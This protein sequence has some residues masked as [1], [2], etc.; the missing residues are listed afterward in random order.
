MVLVSTYAIE[1]GVYSPPMELRRVLAIAFVAWAL[2]ASLASADV[3]I[4]MSDGRVSIVAEAAT[5]AEI[6]AE[7]SRVGRTHFVNVDRLSSDALSLTLDVPEEEALALLLQSAPGY[8]AALRAERASA[9]SRFDR[10]FIMPSRRPD[11]DEE[12]SVAPPDSAPEAE[13]NADVPASAPGFRARPRRPVARSA[14]PASGQFS[15]PQPTVLSPPP[16]MPSAPEGMGAPV[17][18]VIVPPPPVRPPVRQGQ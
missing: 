2:G 15:P 1:D 8:V 11:R 17:P 14:P 9:L 13:A 3:R 4:V 18:G 5:V 7:W 16:T 6:L 10:I 12:A